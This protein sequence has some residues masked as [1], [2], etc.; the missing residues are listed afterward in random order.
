MSE[1]IPI[2]VA[3]LT[4]GVAVYLAQRAH[5]RDLRQKLNDRRISAYAEAVETTLDSIRS[6]VDGTDTANI[7][8]LRKQKQSAE[9]KLY[10]FASD[11]VLRE[12][13]KLNET[14]RDIAGKKLTNDEGLRWAE[15]YLKQRAN[16]INAVRKEFTR[17][18]ID[19]DEMYF[20]IMGQKYDQH[21]LRN[22]NRSAQ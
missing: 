14:V 9:T 22:S 11:S 18:N 16:F 1:L 15:S 7:L 19:N 3:L 13:S 5:I 12:Y 4:G 20:S 10:M 2:L 6:L 8:D 21:Y 17:S